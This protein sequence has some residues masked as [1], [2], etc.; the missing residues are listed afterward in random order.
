[1]GSGHGC[2]SAPEL[3]FLGW[4]TPLAELNNNTLPSGLNLSY[5]LPATNTTEKGAFLVIHIT[6]RSDYTTK[7]TAVYLALRARG[8]GDWNLTSEVTDKVGAIIT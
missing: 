2:P 3:H 4:A 1:M 5:W 7:L 8:G 6:W